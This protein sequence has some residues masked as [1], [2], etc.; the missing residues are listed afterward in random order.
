MER[1]FVAV[2]ERILETCWIW[3]DHDDRPCRHFQ[4]DMGNTVT[5]GGMPSGR[6]G[7]YAPDKELVSTDRL[8]PCAQ[9]R[10]VR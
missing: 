7:G 3:R 2:D 8:W 1:S 10:V 5:V 6:W 9:R 4:A